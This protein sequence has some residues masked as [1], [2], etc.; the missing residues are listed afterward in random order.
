MKNLE[1]AVQNLTEILAEE[2][3]EM[4][5]DIVKAMSFE[6]DNNVE[7]NF[8]C[9]FDDTIDEEYDYDFDA[10]VPLSMYKNM[11]YDDDFIDLDDE[12]DY[13][14]KRMYDYDDFHR[15]LKSVF[16]ETYE[17]DEGEEIDLAEDLVRKVKDFKARQIKPK[18]MYDYDAQFK[19]IREQL[20]QTDRLMV[21][22]ENMM[23]TIADMRQFTYEMMETLD[24]M[25]NE[26]NM[27]EKEIDKIGIR[28]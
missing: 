23:N 4:A 28:Q 17:E 2:A 7:T 18:K 24:D 9:D 8:E 15:T 3:K 11:D 16:G 5:L 19:A 13:Q 21:K 27:L 10:N 25:V 12:E 22:R 20:K 26:L 6:E 1:Q 14:P